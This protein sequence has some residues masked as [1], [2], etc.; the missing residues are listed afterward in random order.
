MKPAGKFAVFGPMLFLA[1]LSWLTGCGCLIVGRETVIDEP[2][3][4][5]QAA[6]I[7]PGVTT[8]HDILEWFGPPS[9]VGRPGTVMKEPRWSKTGAAT[10][11]IRAEEDAGRFDGAWERMQRPLLYYYESA[12]L[13]WTEYGIVGNGGGGPIYI[14]PDKKRTLTVKR[15]WVLIDESS[16]IVVD[17]RMETEVEGKSQPDASKKQVRSET[18]GA[19]PWSP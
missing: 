4:Q 3:T 10:S 8:R 1:G 12:R 11:D 17:H 13:N 7:R 5:E 2:F 16:G 6:K 19:L 15:L 18:E 9:A 14:P